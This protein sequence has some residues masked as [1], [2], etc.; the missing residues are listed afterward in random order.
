MQ[1]KVG[2]VLL[3]V[4]A[5]VAAV[6]VWQRL[7][8]RSGTQGTAAQQLTNVTS[9]ID[10]AVTTDLTNTTAAT[11]PL[12]IEVM[13]RQ[14]YPGSGITV[15]QSLPSGSNYSRAVV[16]YESEGNTIY[17]L[18]T[19]P[20]GQK[21]ASGWP[22]VVFNHGYIP[23][24]QYR[25]T[26][27]YVGYVDYFARN[28]YIV[29]KSDYRGHG[30]SEG[31]ASGGY[32]SPGYTVDVLNAV[33][34]LKQHPD[35]DENRMGMWGHSMGG[36]ITLRSMV[37]SKDIKAGVIWGGVVASYKDLLENWRRRSSSP[38]PLPSG[39]RRW[40]ETLQQLYGTPGDNPTFWNSISANSYLSDLSGPIQLHHAKGDASVPWE[41]SQTLDT[42]I[43]TAGKR[44]ELFL[45]EG[46]DHDIT[47]NFGKAMQES[48]EFF[49]T[50]VKNAPAPSPN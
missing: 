15:V 34:S 25:T 36:Y 29:F 46:D 40:R 24:A 5:A 47:R 21:P 20:N 44:S 13:R 6:V 14:A 3:I 33:S 18:M 38:P 28:G 16:S 9:G 41:F 7:P 23:P 1:K 26:E 31:E 27:R 12:Q 30:S 39:A 48:L 37:I 45:Y 49:D 11:N 32:G 4:I 19:V 2:V 8:V 22:V 42:E 10:E 50:H 43:K 35:V 17:A